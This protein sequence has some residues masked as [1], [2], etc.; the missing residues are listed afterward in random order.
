MFHSGIIRAANEN[1]HPT[2]SVV[3]PIAS[4][5]F[6][7]QRTQ[8]RANRDIQPIIIYEKNGSNGHNRRGF[9]SRR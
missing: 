5:I 8:S 2:M 4:W 3:S 9:W 6:A 1:R 7:A